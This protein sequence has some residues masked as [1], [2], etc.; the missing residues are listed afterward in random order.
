MPPQTKSI[1]DI[2]RESD[3][4]SALSD[5][6]G[7]AT[8]IDTRSSMV[9]SQ[10]FNLPSVALATPERAPEIRQAP[11]DKR[12]IIQ[13]AADK[14]Y[15]SG[16][17]GATAAAVADILPGIPFVDI[18]DPPH[19]L[20][21]PQMQT[22]R[23]LLGALSIPMM[24]KQAPKAV[25]RVATNIKQPFSYEPI[26]QIKENLGI[27]R[28]KGRTIYGDPYII[29]PRDV[30]SMDKVKNISQAIGKTIKSIA[31]DKPLYPMDRVSKRFF[32]RG[33]DADRQKA[34]SEA[35][36]YLYRKTFGLK[37]RRG[38]KIFKENKDGTL[39][40]NPKSKRAKILI[41]DIKKGVM[42][43]A[44]GLKGNLVEKTYTPQHTVMGGYSAKVKLG[45]NFP[46][47]AKIDYKDIWDFK[48]HPSEWK[49]IFQPNIHLEGMAKY[50]PYGDKRAQIGGAALRTFVNAITT[51]PVIKGTMP[52][53][54]RAIQAY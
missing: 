3:I 23:N 51:P 6:S 38:I 48:M 19:Q 26:S 41:E 30:T 29:H 8:N 35:R 40:F 43:E 2:I 49:D 17:I 1:D 18:I 32:P 44:Y 13:K 45:K 50:F 53:T 25:G 12:N 33:I 21:D 20:E 46:L 11:E 47:R 42:K 27:G 4:I 52:L 24:M 36:E 31:K 7:D 5:M 15:E 54:N 14:L 22:A 28:Y 9:G 16:P 39:S 37:P 10:T 34:G